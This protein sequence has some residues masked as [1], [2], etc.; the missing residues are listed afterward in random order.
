[1]EQ[2]I[3]RR[4]RKTRQQLRQALMQ[5]M[6]EKPVNE[7]S[8]REI[9]E[10]C[11]INRGTFY[12]HYRDVFDMVESVEREFT[13]DFAAM[14]SEYEVKDSTDLLQ[15]IYAVFEF[16]QSHRDICE[17]ILGKYG[18]QQF[19]KT[20]SEMFAEKYR[21]LWEDS[22][23]RDPLMFSRAFSFAVSGTVGVMREWLFS[24]D[25]EPPR[26]LAAA[27]YKMIFE[28]VLRLSE[29]TAENESPPT[30]NKASKRR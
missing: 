24:P 30:P 18:N 23:S 26:Q 3:D 15:L 5:L 6:K 20:F 4:V 8:V 22:R 13:D 12:L 29:D 10:L 1:M 14:L 28:G 16:L 7:I 2:K 27:V 19:I 17:A 25:P 11:D 9:A 21:Y